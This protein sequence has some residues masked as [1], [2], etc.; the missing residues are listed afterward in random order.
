MLIP[1][2]EHEGSEHDN[3]EGRVDPDK[4]GT[5]EHT[6]N[7]RQEKD[8]GAGVVGEDVGPLH[9]GQTSLTEIVAYRLRNVVAI[10]GLNFG[11]E[12]LELRRHLLL[13]R[14]VVGVEELERLLDEMSF[15]RHLDIFLALCLSVV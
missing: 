10:Q 14:A 6:D 13:H 15:P 8:I 5:G 4:V 9:Q 12:L 1:H 2:V 7:E 11:K 3:L